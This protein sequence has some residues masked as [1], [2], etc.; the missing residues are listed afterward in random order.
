MLLF[1]TS[2]YNKIEFQI[3]IELKIIIKIIKNSTAKIRKW[4]LFIWFLC[5]MA[6][7][8]VVRVKHLPLWRQELIIAREPSV[9]SFLGDWSKWTWLHLT[10][11][12]THAFNLLKFSSWKVHDSR[13]HIIKLFVLLFL[14]QPQL[15]IVLWRCVKFGWFL[16][17]TCPVRWA[18]TQ[19]K[20]EGKFSRWP[21]ASEYL[22]SHC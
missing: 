1:W 16:L 17:P 10:Y 15:K 13:E 12:F 3:D 14:L 19:K 5:K 20:Q 22:S 8:V 21:A 18:Q 6:F 7:R 2:P 9:I 11:S 4:A